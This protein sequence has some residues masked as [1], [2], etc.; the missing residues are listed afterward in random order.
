MWHLITFARITVENKH[1][2]ALLE[3]ERRQVEG[4]VARQ[5]GALR[6]ECQENS[7]SGANAFVNASQCRSHRWWPSSRF[8]L[9]HVTEPQSCSACV[10][11]HTVQFSR[12]DHQTR[13]G[14]ETFKII[15]NDCYLMFDGTVAK[16]EL[17]SC[18]WGATST[19]SEA[20]RHFNDT[21]NSSS[22]QRLL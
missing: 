17:P 18:S 5:R 9:W 10:K 4:F 21:L 15:L 6:E 1:N 12:K 19:K 2:V 7:A 8:K 22:P 11:D 3:A 13:A 20:R 14:D 16:N